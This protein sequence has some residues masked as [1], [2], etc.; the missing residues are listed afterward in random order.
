M[1][2]R[3]QASHGPARI[4]SA[5]C[6]QRDLHVTVVE[7]EDRVM[8][9]VVS[10]NVSDYYQLKHTNNGVKLLL[11]TRLT[12]FEGRRRV[13]RVITDDD[14]KLPASFV[15]IG[16]G[17]VP[18]TELASAAGLDVDDGI[19]VDDTCLTSDPDVYAIGDCTSHPNA[20]YG[21]RLRLESV[22]NALE[23]AKT[24]ASNICGDE[25]HYCQVPWFWSDQYDL[26]LQIAGLSQGHDDV[27]LRGE[28]SSGSFA[29][30]Y[31]KDGVLVAVDAINSPKE[32]VQ[33]KSLIANRA[34]VSPDKLRDPD[35]VLKDLA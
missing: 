19:V 3:I 32:F 11:S 1:P 35:V 18:N 21:Q 13:Q 16:V 15:V 28:P 25:M 14:Q 31:L 20:I 23:Q 4:S 29:C 8:S 2:G 34:K 22:H 6:R 30:F 10:P 33:A 9:R 24:A 5:V 7:L 27:V 26:K 17:I 12:G